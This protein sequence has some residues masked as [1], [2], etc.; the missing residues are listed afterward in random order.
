VEY[1][2]QPNNVRL[3]F[4]DVHHVDYL[5]TS[6]QINL[7]INDIDINGQE[8]SELVR[9]IKEELLGS[10]NGKYAEKNSAGFSLYQEGMI[11]PKLSFIINLKGSLV[12][13]LLINDRNYVLNS[14][15]FL[16][17]PSNFQY[18]IDKKENDY[19]ILGHATYSNKKESLYE[20]ENE[21]RVISTIMDEYSLNVNANNEE[22]A[23]NKASLIDISQWN[24][25]DLYPELED[26]VITKF[27][28]WGN[29][30][31]DK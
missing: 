5:L 19:F 12:V 27:S 3:K 28:K 8:K 23:I 6:D 4:T 26:R 24:H 17:F 20:G 2:E 9:S 15:S 21:Y 13:R 30:R 11:L 18:I 22:D 7:I 14:G 1:M 29:F 31:I 25:L 16:M 10:I